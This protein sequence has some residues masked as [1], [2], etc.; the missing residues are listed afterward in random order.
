MKL[1]TKKLIRRANGQ[2]LP[3]KLWVIKRDT[4]VACV[5]Y[6]YPVSY[7]HLSNGLAHKIELMQLIH[8]VVACTTLNFVYF[9]KVL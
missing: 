8:N 4:T 9:D 5:F 7:T 3:P 1:F 2:K 6:L